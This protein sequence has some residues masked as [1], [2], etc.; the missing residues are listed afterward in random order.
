MGEI[1]RSLGMAAFG[2]QATSS[3]VESMKVAW[4]QATAK[5]IGCHSFSAPEILKLFSSWVMEDGGTV[6]EMLAQDPGWP[7]SLTFFFPSPFWRGKVNCLAA[8]NEGDYPRVEVTLFK[9]G[10]RQHRGFLPD[11]VKL[12]IL[13]PPGGE[14]RWGAIPKEVRDLIWAARI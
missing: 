14:S 10:N 8:G 9:M 2:S 13:S 11:S 12:G 3:E 1:S 5:H 7:H 4:T 6:S